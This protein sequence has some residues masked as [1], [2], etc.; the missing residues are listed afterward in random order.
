ME[1]DIVKI[2]A[3]IDKQIEDVTGIK[4]EVQ[5]SPETPPIV[6][7]PV[8]PEIVTPPAEKP[9][10]DQAQV[11]EKEFWQVPN[12]GVTGETKEEDWKTKYESVNGEYSG[13]KSKI[14]SDLVLKRLFELKDSPNFDLPAFLESQIAKKLD[15]TKVPIENLYKASLEGDKIANYTD[16]EIETLW[17]EKKEELK[18]N[19]TKEKTL[20]SELVKEFQSQQPEENTEEPELLKTWKTQKE[21]QEVARQKSIKE[22]QEVMEG[23]KNYTQGLIGKKMGG[24]EITQEDVD[25]ANHRAS[26]DYYKDKEGKINHTLIAV[27]RMKATMWDKSQTYFKSDAVIEARKQITRPSTD[28]AGGQVGDTDGRTE[29]EKLLD[30]AAQDLGLKDR[31][32]IIPKK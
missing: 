2:Q 28:R 27:D 4:S 25:M 6:A 20:K 19:P 3:E 21:Q 17:E 5:A 22:H 23:I 9:N 30:K 12:L 29:E 14:E 15:F 32:D 10:V 13:L 16:E 31:F 18:G 11:E 24:V 26:I 7:D 8:I 1:T